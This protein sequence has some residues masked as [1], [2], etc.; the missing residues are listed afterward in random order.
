[1]SEDLHERLSDRTIVGVLR[2][3]DLS[4]CRVRPRASQIHHIGSIRTPIVGYAENFK[5]NFPNTTFQEL[6]ERDPSTYGHILNGI[7]RAQD[8]YRVHF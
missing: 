2:S 3:I 6:R 4:L 1:M 5:R 7:R 8:N